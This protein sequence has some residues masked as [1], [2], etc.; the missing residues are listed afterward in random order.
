MPCPARCVVQV[1]LLRLA[2]NGDGGGHALEE[3][4]HCSCSGVFDFKW[5]PPS[6]VA[7]QGSM[8][9]VAA[10]AD[11]SCRLLQLTSEAVT[12]GP[13]AEGAAGS[14]MAL[15]CDWQRGGTGA[16]VLV[17]SSDG[18]LSRC[19]LREASFEVAH[20]WHGHDLE[21]W[22]IAS[23]PHMVRREHRRNGMRIGLPAAPSRCARATSV[24]NSSAYGPSGSR[25]GGEPVRHV[26]VHVALSGGDDCC[27]KGWD[28]RQPDSPAFVERRTHTAGV[29]CV[30][31]HP[32]RE[33]MIATGSYDDIARV[34][35][36]RSL[37]HPVLSCQVRIGRC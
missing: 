27:L 18:S 34:W 14:G 20:Q 21:A 4:A 25:C 32:S 13:A 36:M 6:D 5:R 37:A 17:S 28:T 7:D 10:L 2:P 16:G 1:S 22:M 26:Q 11:G 3:A 12:P 8:N 31:P 33:C 9:A 19:A 29:C 23:H 30:H 24:V 35:D 15:S